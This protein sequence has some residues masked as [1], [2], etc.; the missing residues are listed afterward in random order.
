MA[1]L[2]GYTEDG[3]HVKVEGEPV[4]YGNPQCK[5]F[6]DG[7]EV[8]VVPPTSRLRDGGTTTIP[9]ERGTIVAHR[10]IG[11]EPFNSFDGE[12]LYEKIQ[13]VGVAEPG[14]NVLRWK[15]MGGDGKTCED[16]LRDEL[17]EEL[18]REIYIATQPLTKSKVEWEAIPD[19]AKD[20]FYKETDAVLTLL[21]LRDL[22]KLPEMRVFHVK[23]DD[24]E[25]M[26]AHEFE[27][28][29]PTARAA[30]FRAAQETIRKDPGGTMPAF[31]DNPSV[32]DETMVENIDLVRQV[33]MCAVVKEKT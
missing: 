15:P 6:I 4:P 2:E 30:A 3:T 8:P 27:I 17:R 9:T 11:Q 22:L 25:A 1:Y 19:I 21:E 10:R 24:P 7:E 31:R 32:P 18:A 23:V 29:A 16:G 14:N 12:R 5:V 13:P 28:E 33:A 26:Q 20:S